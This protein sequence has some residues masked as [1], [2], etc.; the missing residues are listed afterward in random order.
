MEEKWHV[1]LVCKLAGKVAAITG[2]ASGIVKATAAEL[3]RNNGAK[4]VIADI[5]DDLGCKWRSQEFMAGGSYPPHPPPT[6]CP[7]PSDRG[8]YRA[9]SP[10]PPDELP[11]PPPPGLS[12]PPPSPLSPS[13]HGSPRNPN[14]LSSAASLHYPG[15][16]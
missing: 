8:R 2:G 5:Q 10:T 13:G 14:P 1:E 11:P 3:V 12:P 7:T 15:R 6:G 4:V 16:R 9:P